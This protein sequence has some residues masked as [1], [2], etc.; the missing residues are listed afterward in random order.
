MYDGE[1]YQRNEGIPDIFKYKSLEK[2]SAEKLQVC[3]CQARILDSKPKAY[4]SPDMR[5]VI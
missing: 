3:S 4:V 5:A 1:F 2:K